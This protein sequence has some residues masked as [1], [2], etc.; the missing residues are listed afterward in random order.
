MYVIHLI[1][2][3]NIG[4]YDWQ[5]LVAIEKVNRNHPR[6]AD[7]IDNKRFVFVLSNAT[8]PHLPSFVGQSDRAVIFKNKS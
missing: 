4:R 5:S 2:L 1:I 7:W 8:R 6:F 3:L